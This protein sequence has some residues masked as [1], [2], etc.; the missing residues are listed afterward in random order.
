MR[1]EQLCEVDLRYGG[2]FH[3]AVP[4]GSGDGSGRGSG[5]GS[6][7]GERLSGTAQWSSDPRRKRD[8]AMLPNARGVITTGDGLE[9]LFNLTAR[10]VFIDRDR[11]PRGSN[12]S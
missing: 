12:C 7:V 9:V 10:T 8:G 4:Y 1:L 3:T 2:P 6:V 11:S 5:E